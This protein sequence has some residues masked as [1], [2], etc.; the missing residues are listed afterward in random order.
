MRIADQVIILN[1]GQNSSPCHPN[2]VPSIA[3]RHLPP[4]ISFIAPSG[5]G[6][7]T[8]IEAVVCELKKRGYKI[9]VIKH[10][11]HQFEIDHPGKDSFRSTAAGSD[12]MVIASKTK[13]ALVKN[14]SKPESVESIVCQYFAD[15]D[16]VLTEGYSEGSFPKILIRRSTFSGNHNKFKSQSELNIVAVASDTPAEGHTSVKFE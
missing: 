4:V 16:L 8:L 1:N 11:A 7:T 13:L 10:D 15:A 9:G 12:I 2:F 6:K 5:M 14:C 3:R